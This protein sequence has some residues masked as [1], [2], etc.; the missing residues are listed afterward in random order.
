[1]K[2]KLLLIVTLFV[3]TYG[4]YT[5]FKASTDNSSII[6]S[7][8]VTTNLIIFTHLMINIYKNE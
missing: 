2:N 4:L 3:I 8:L 6:S 1:M 5:G 7:L